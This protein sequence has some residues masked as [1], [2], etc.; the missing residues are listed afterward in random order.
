MPPTYE[1]LYQGRERN[2]ATIAKDGQVKFA[3][4]NKVNC[5]DISA[6][7]TEYSYEVL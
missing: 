6:F 5:M 2:I 7:S 4:S 3:K 1:L